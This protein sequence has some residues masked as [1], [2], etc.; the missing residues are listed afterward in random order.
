MLTVNIRRKNVY[1][2]FINS[3]FKNKK[4]IKDKYNG[5]FEKFNKEFEITDAMI[6][7]LRQLAEN[8]GVVWDEERAKIDEPYW[9][10][11]L[12][13]L[14]ARIIWDNNCEAK[15]ISQIDRQLKTATT[16]FPIAEK[17]RNQKVKSK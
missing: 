6:K 14:I 2:E 16:L 12:K 17:I 4:H 5:D 1:N 13:A 10:L 3:E 8:K 11:S 9:K 15:I 7:K